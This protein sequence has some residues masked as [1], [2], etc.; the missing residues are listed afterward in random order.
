MDKLM[1]FRK[2]INE[3]TEQKLSIN[4]LIIKA[5]AKASSDVPEAN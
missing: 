3:Q 1:A 5:V 4:D 2:N